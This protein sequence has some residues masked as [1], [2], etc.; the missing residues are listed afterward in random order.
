M[1]VVQVALLILWSVVGAA[2]LVWIISVAREE[3]VMNRALVDWLHHDAGRE[4]ALPRRGRAAGQRTRKA[5]DTIRDRSG[6]PVGRTLR[7]R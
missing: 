1:G 7:L 5:V 6:R 3:F 2:A 4:T